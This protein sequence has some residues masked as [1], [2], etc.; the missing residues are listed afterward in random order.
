MPRVGFE[1][2]TLVFGR[3]KT[4][5]ALDSAATVIGIQSIPPHP[6]SLKFA[7]ILSFRL[8]L[9]VPTGLFHSGFPIKIAARIPLLSHACYMS[10][11]PILLGLVVVILF[12]EEYKL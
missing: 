1:P 3:A 5:H 11:H 10:C 8:G 9:R 7:R 12:G 2:T 4:V 6:S